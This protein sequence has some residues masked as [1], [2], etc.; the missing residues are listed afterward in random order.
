MK[1]I[2]RHF[3]FF[4]E[5]I[6][7]AQKRI[8]NQNQLTKQK[9]ANKKQQRQQVFAHAQKFLRGWKSFILCFGAFCTLKI[10]S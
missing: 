1:T 6:L 3:F 9:Q 10:F 7:N 8:S 2:S 4:N 5:K